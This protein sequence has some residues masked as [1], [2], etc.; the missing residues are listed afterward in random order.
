MNRDKINEQQAKLRIES[1]MTNAERVKH[2]DVVLTTLW[3]P[4][5]TQKQVRESYITANSLVILDS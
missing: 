4:A 2:A 1:Q 3:E 5:I